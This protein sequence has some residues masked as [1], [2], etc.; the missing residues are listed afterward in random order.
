M[1][2]DDSFDEPFDF[3]TKRL[4]FSVRLAFAMSINK[5]NGQT[6]SVCDINL[7]NPCFSHGQL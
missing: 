1:H 6:L 5:S 3:L 4:Q 7:E 2:F